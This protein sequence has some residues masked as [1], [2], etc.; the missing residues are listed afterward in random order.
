LNG[1]FV[2]GS[3]VGFAVRHSFRVAQTRTDHDLYVERFPE[4]K[5]PLDTKKIIAQIQARGHDGEPNSLIGHASSIAGAYSG[6]Q[7]CRAR[8]F[9]YAQDPK[10][11]RRSNPLLALLAILC[12]L[13]ATNSS[14]LSLNRFT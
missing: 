10:Q 9:L 8:S 11:K 7:A 5:S 4:E 12:N 14:V 6:S 3:E 2:G 1:A 13:R